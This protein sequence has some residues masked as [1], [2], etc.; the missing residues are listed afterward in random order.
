M[1]QLKYSPNIGGS[2]M[3]NMKLHEEMLN[4]PS[5][6]VRACVD[7]ARER[8]AIYQ[9]EIDDVSTEQATSAAEIKGIKQSFSLRRWFRSKFFGITA[10]EARQV[11][12]SYG[13]YAEVVDQIADENQRMESAKM[14]LSTAVDD[15]N[16]SEAVQTHVDQLIGMLGRLPK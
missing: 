15:L 12:E 1:E 11:A 9:Q 2:I 16:Y 3:T 14:S 7:E 6:D 5:K 13:R 10:E 4:G 8:M